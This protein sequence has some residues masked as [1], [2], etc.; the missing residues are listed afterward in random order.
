MHVGNP[1]DKGNQEVDSGRKGLDVLPEPLDHE[2]LLLGH[3]SNTPIHRRPNYSTHYHPHHKKT[4][5]SLHAAPID[6]LKHQNL[7]NPKTN[8]TKKQ[9][10]KYAHGTHLEGSRLLRKWRT[11]SKEWEGTSAEDLLGSRGCGWLKIEGGAAVERALKELWL[12]LLI[13]LPAAAARD[14][15]WDRDWRR[16]LRELAFKN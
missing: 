5:F 7:T 15:D 4:K 6:P 11:A 8:K 10:G 1:I 13:M 3:N 14:W 12:L 16:H 2:G 9:A